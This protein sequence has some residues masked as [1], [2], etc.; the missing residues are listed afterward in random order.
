MPGQI[1]AGQI[2]SINPSAD[3]ANQ[4]PRQGRTNELVVTE[5]HGKYAEQSF[6]GRVFAA[7]AAALA[8]TTPGTAMTFCLANPPG[9]GVLVK[10]IRV[11][12]G[13]V[14]APGTQALGYLGLYAGKFSGV[15]VTGTAFGT[16][17]CDRI[18]QAANPAAAALFTA[19]LPAAPVLYRV[20]EN[21]FGA[22]A[23]AQTQA[24]GIDF[25]GTCTL[26]PGTSISIGQNVADTTT[27]AV[28][29]PVFVWE[30]W[31]FTQ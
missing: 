18:A 11:D 4:P 6:R 10:P 30:E 26:D 20:I 23:T 2:G 31:L 28:V 5:L 22:L 19:T 16:V 7:S 29:S 25:D 27:N 12:I 24:V 21:K 8:L 14:T 3:G 13:Y 15:A 1:I 9:S 17:L